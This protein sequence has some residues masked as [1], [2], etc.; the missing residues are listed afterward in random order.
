M[1]YTFIHTYTRRC[2]AQETFCEFVRVINGTIIIIITT[3]TQLSLPDMRDFALDQLGALH[4]SFLYNG[5]T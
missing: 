2:I 3:G 5:K 4:A 1:Q